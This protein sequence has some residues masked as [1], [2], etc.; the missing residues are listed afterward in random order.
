MQPSRNVQQRQSANV[1]SYHASRSIDQGARD[2][3]KTPA[4]DSKVARLSINKAKV[5]NYTPSLLAG[6][7][8]I[9]CVAYLSTL[10]SQVKI[11][12]MGDN[13]TARTLQYTKYTDDI[14]KLLS[15]S[16]YNKSKLLIDTDKVAKEIQQEFPELGEVLVILPFAGR[17]PIIQVSP[18][19]PALILGTRSG[20]YVVDGGGRVISK[21]SELESSARSNLP[22]LQD[23]SGLTIE[24]GKY[25]LPDESV[26]FVRDIASQVALRGYNI[27]SLSLPNVANE[28]HLRLIDQPYYIKFDLTGDSR[29]QSG[30][31]FAVRA[32][33]AKDGV[34]PR[35]YIDVRVPGKA[36]YK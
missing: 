3:R 21:A 20:G 11:Q 8:V 30:T 9:V 28:V 32:K 14:Q 7:V 31:Y 10:S 12:V 36:Y 26:S 5:L 35:E 13:D 17:R 24:L 6:F 4:K 23:E 18:K 19:E 34:T 1:F 25:A 27:R 33:L 15:S 22:V 29:V 16:I 2:R